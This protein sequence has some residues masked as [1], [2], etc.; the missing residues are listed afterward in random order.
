MQEEFLVPFGAGEAA[1]TLAQNRQAS[2]FCGGADAFYGAAMQRRV[3]D[4]AST[5]HIS[6]VEF[7]LRL[8]QKEKLG[9]AGGQGRECGQNL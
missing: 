7:K 2:G 6:A 3:A 8:H 5:A 1:G 9:A 4:D